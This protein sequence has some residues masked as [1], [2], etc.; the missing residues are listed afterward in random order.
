MNNFPERLKSARL[1][2]GLS[3]QDLVNKLDNQV[4]KMAISRYENGVMKPNS[5]LLL[6]ICEA[7]N[8][9]VDYFY[10]ENSIELKD[11]EYRKF[12]SFGKKHQE[13]IK[14]RTIEFLE[15]YLELE[16]IVG[17]QIQFDHPLL[18][19]K[20]IKTNEDVEAAA[21]EVRKYW[22]LGEDPIY[23]ALELLE[24]KGMRIFE[25]EEDDTFSGLM[26]TSNSNDKII[27]LNN[28]KTIPSERKRFTAFHELGHHILKFNP[29]LSEREREKLC[30]YFAGAMLISKDR[31][32]SEL[33]S[34]RQNIHL[35][36]LGLIKL[37]YGISMQALLFRARN[38]NIISAS[39]FNK[40]LNLFKELKIN[41]VE[42]T[43][44]A[45]NGDET[46]SRF[47][48]ILIRGYAEGIISASKASELY[49]VSLPK[50]MKELSI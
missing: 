31:M 34:H 6:A 23:N 33:G 24:E 44:F 22:K 1:L 35:V 4:S 28:D 48:Q 30:H 18:E 46:P 9:S 7:L 37:Q 19:Y 26:A 8:V 14:Q 43:S 32:I 45:Y 36:E 29:D 16:S 2:A 49:N 21:E 47:K 50:F 27:V 20:E 13:Q 39:Y 41:K 42:P 17:E 15:R 25:V 38:L 11:V 10:R 40:L 12:S 5:E 3:M